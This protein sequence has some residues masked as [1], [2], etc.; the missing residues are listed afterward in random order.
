[1]EFS[2]QKQ[3]GEKGRGRKKNG[4]RYVLVSSGG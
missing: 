3:R 2:D 4:I 1:M